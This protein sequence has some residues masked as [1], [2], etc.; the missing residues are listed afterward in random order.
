MSRTVRHYDSNAARFVEDT[1]HVDM[2]ALHARFLAHIPVGGLILDAGCGSGRDS[3]AFLE[4]GFRVRAFDGSAEL[5]RLAAEYL[6][7][8]VDVKRFD[9]IVECSRY[10]G[11]WACASLL[12]VGEE[13]LPAT[14]AR[15]WA[16][17]KPGG[18]FYLSFKHGEVE[19]TDGER[20]FT[21]A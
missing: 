21:D 15:M 6:G 3:K 16:S 20:H 18:V 8:P 9:E 4:A 17:L 19:R 14:L 1:L 2:S 10:D 7:Q 13:E 12:H 11:I 5:A